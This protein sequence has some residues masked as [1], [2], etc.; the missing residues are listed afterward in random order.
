VAITRANQAWAQ[1][2]TY[3]SM[4]EGFMYLTAILDWHSRKVL[5]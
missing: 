4:E 3:V 1:D 5:S 2:I